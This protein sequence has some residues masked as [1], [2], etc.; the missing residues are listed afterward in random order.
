[1]AQA[2]LKEDFL[3]SVFYK[4]ERTGAFACVFLFF[5]HTLHGIPST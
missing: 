2:V 4:M 3:Y 5:Y 1:M